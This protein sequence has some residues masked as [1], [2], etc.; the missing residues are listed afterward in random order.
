MAAA[1]VHKSPHRSH[2]RAPRARA[3]STARAR[4]GLRAASRE[5]REHVLYAAAQQAIV[6]VGRVDLGEGRAVP[7]PGSTRAVVGVHPAEARARLGRGITALHLVARQRAGAGADLDDQIG[8]VGRLLVAA[9]LKR[10][11][12]Q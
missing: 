10:R 9:L 12:D 6:D 8:V 1:G 4:P 3:W 2:T 7:N 11:L 5:R